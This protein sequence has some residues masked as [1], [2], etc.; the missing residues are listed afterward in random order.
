MRSRRAPVFVVN[1]SHLRKKYL[2]SQILSCFFPT[3]F[4]NVVDRTGGTAMYVTY[5]N[6]FKLLIDKGLN[7][8]E[9]A[10]EVGIS[11]NTLAKLSKNEL[12]SLEV[13]VRICR[14]LDCSLG[15]IVQIAPSEAPIKND[16]ERRKKRTQSS[17]KG[18]SSLYHE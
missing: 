17:E 9:F 5:N 10:R 14:K 15:D 16:L 6:L 4:Y 18:G 11:S 7:K 2:L 12:V 13:L 3:F 1:L 8:T